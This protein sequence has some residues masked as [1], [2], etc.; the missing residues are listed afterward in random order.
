MGLGSTQQAPVQP[1]GEVVGLPHATA[2]GV[3]KQEV[4][5]NRHLWWP[6]IHPSMGLDQMDFWCSQL[7]DKDP[8]FWH[9]ANHL[10]HPPPQPQH[11]NCSGSLFQSN[12]E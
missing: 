12:V 1:L 10:G 3:P 8:P 5:S 4:S 6:I 11:S 2:V 9:C 7:A